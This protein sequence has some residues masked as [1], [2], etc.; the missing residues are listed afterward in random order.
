[1]ERL[2]LVRLEL[3]EFGQWGRRGGPRSRRRKGEEGGGGRREDGEAERA[4]V[5]KGRGKREGGAG[6]RDAWEVLPHRRAGAHGLPVQNDVLL[7][8]LEALLEALVDGVD[9]CEGV[10]DR[11]VSRALPVARVVVPE[12]VNAQLI[13]QVPDGGAKHTAHLSS[14]SIW[15]IGTPHIRLKSGLT[16]SIAA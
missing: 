14:S 6:G 13:R 8:H 1:M 11:E 5:E 3:I 16:G 7:G 4:A 9:V 12:D 10:E 2:E 15:S